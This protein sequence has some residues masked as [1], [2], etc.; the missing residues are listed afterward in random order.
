M[1]LYAILCE[2]LARQAYY[3][4]AVS[5]HVVDIELIDKGLH[6]EPARLR[7]HL[8]ARIAA[9]DEQGY[10]ALLLGFGLCSHSTVGLHS[11]HT[12]LVLPRAHDCIT[13]FLGSKERYG[14]EF[15]ATPGTY[16]YAPD[17]YERGGNQSGQVALGAA[18]DASIADV[19]QEYVT[20]YGQDNAD[21]LM[22]VMGAWQQ[23]YSRAAYVSPSEMA[24]PD[25]RPAVREIAA[26]RG[27]AFQELAGSL[28]LV[29]GLIDGQWP[30]EDYQLVPPGEMLVATN[31]EH[32]MGSRP[33]REEDADGT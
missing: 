8:Q 27:W 30:P 11:R 13:L 29:R 25:Y 18:D 32:I 26:R 12:P 24:L 23:H 2:V 22:E 4:A 1:R 20:K 6:N 19:Y 21:Y 3:A 7:A 10:D 17:Y 33:Y 15:R 14:D 16:W 31:D 9:V 28:V 5:P